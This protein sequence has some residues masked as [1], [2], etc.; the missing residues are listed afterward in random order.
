MHLLQFGDDFEMRQATRSEVVRAS[1]VHGAGHDVRAALLS[2]PMAHTNWRSV[3]HARLLKRMPEARRCVST[4]AP[5]DLAWALDYLLLQQAANVLI[6]NGG[7]GTVHHC[8]NV[9]FP[10]LERIEATHGVRVPAPRILFVNGGGMNMLARVF[11]TRGHPVR[12]L[13]VFNKQVD[14]GPLGALK[15]QTIELLQVTSEAETRYG[16][17]FGS[18]LVH[19]ALV[20]YERFGRGYRGLSRFLSKLLWAYATKNELWDRFGHMILPPTSSV[21]VD[22]VTTESYG[23]VVASTVPMTLAGGLVRTLAQ[24]PPRG[25]LNTVEVRARTP[26]EIISTIPFLLAGSRGP[27]FRYGQEVQAVQVTGPYTLDGELFGRAT[28]PLDLRASGKV[29]RGI[30]L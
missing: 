24:A 19:N 6:L 8:L 16:F 11:G 10:L 27:G 17:I 25:M 30:C 18:E 28:G 21:E 12:T 29:I 15:T 7:D 4:P 20:L 26:T 23:A 5:S 22:G 1:Q 13:Q 3:A 2:N 9:L 14:H